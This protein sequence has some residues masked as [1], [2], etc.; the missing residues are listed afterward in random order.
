MEIS[1]LYQR[2]D[3]LAEDYCFYQQVGDWSLAE[4]ARQQWEHIYALIQ[5]GRRAA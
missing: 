3:A 4:L 5:G 2:L 1:N